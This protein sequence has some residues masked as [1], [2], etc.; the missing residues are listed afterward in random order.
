MAKTPSVR[1][2]EPTVPIIPE[3]KQ[4][5]QQQTKKRRATSQQ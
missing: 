3:V 2:P 1:D 4:Q 5:Q